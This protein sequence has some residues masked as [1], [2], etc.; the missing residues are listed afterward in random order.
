MNGK[1]V[2]IT[3]GTG[4]IGK[5]TA[6]GI[7]K[8][9]ATVVVTGRDKALGMAAVTEI[10]RA[11]DNPRID[12]ML[13]DLSDQSEIHRLAHDV[14]AN[15]ARLDVLINNLGGL[16]SR[17][18]LTKDGIEAT[19]AMNH[20]TPFLLTHLLLDMLVATAPARV[21]NVT[22]GM[23][24]MP[25]DFGNLQAERSFLGLQTYSHAKAVMM[26]A[27]REFAQ[28]LRGTG[29]TLNV[30]YPGA[31]ATAMT[32]A[33]TPNMVPW[34]MRLAW[35]AFKLFM[36]NAKPSRAARSS[37]YLA[38]VPEL[39]GVSGNYYDTNS[40]LSTWPIA[41]RD[42]SIRERL[43]QVSEE[44]TGLTD[45]SIGEPMHQVLALAQS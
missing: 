6:I 23:P 35:P 37:I 30:A 2:L 44:L 9:G 45:R 33:M 7:A 22:G 34:F 40:K 8:L 25:I 42:A 5:E 13:A 1:T 24:T 26:A 14:K 12:L 11:S 41:A 19:L 4:G 27:S 3:G 20:L 16:Y 43:W 32:A 10:Q 29:V 38:S 15:Y 18:W 36:G 39:A 17:R 21:V 31:A 28:R